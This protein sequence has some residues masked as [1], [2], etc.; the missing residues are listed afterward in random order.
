MTTT[1]RPELLDE[2]LSG[3]KSPDDLLGDG[4]VFRQ[5]KKALLEKVLGAALAHH[6]G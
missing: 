1:I 6:L 2:P 4:G 5:L 3:V